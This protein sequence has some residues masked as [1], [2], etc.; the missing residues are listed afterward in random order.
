LQSA[1]GGIAKPVNMLTAYIGIFQAVC[2]TPVKMA[3]WNG[4]DWLAGLA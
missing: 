1:E 3:S 4:L 2:K